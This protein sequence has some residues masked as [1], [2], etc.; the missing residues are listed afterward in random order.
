MSH[1]LMVL[2]IRGNS[3]YKSTKLASMPPALSC[4]SVTAL[5]LSQSHSPSPLPL[6]PFNRMKNMP[7]KLFFIACIQ[8]LLGV[9]QAY[10]A[11]YYVSPN[12]ADTNNG[13]T[14]STPVKTIRQALSKAWSTGD[15]IYVRAGTYVETVN[16]GQS[17]ITLSAYKDEK[18][19]ID[20]QTSLPSG[21]W[22]SL[23]S[24]SGNNNKISGFEVKNCNINGA[25]LGGYGITVTG[26]HNTTSNMNV[27]HIWEQ[28]VIINGDYNIV[29]DSLVWQAAR[30][31]SINSGSTGWGTGL[32]AAR[33]NSA[34]AIKPGITSYA[35][36]R[37]N[38]V[39]NNWGEGLSCFQTDHCTLKDNIVYDN[40]TV[41]LYLSDSTNSLV[42]RNLVYVSTQPAIP[43]RNNSHPGLVLA[44]EVATAPRSASNSVI[45]NFIYNTN[46]SAFSW[47]GVTN[48]GLNNVLIANNTIVDGS[49]STG[50]GGGVVN[51]N[52]QIRNNIILGRNSYVPSNNGITFSNNNWSVIPANAASSTNIVGDPQVSR[53]GTATPG[54]LTPDYFKILG[55]SPVI[56]A[57]MPLTQVAKDY[58]Q[59]TRGT[60]P[61]IGGYEFPISITSAIDSTAPSGLN[62]TTGSSKVNLAWNAST[63]N[64]GVTGN[65]SASSNMATVKT[66]PLAAVKM[67]SYNVENI[68]TNNAVISWTTDASSTGVV[69]YGTSASDLSSK[70]TVSNLATSQSVNITELTRGTTYYYRI[71]ANSGSATTL[72]DTFSFTTKYKALLNKSAIPI[73][74]H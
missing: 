48:S 43:T 16:V 12:G 64:V 62:A 38:R 52:S 19:V 13:T 37:R 60:A 57:A 68:T 18:P 1:K 35:T 26:H 31:N 27:H 63:D 6:I 44:D 42:Q 14:L 69:S 59:D 70:V 50:S 17:G 67:T 15:I 56:N 51:T 20:G 33:N 11:T 73:P 74:Q 9:Q 47:T 10:A 24:V 66:A 3:V 2:C 46:L 30:K 39:F 36:L 54:N 55:T 21:D 61:D 5:N 29:E 71:T 45:N 23:V 28:G 32:S 8:G 53:T 40:W 41:N 65:L 72:S 25:H 22:G 34:A 4:S 58:F 7:R 49:I